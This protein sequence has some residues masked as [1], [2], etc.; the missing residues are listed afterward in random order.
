MKEFIFLLSL[1]IIT[2]SL[3]KEVSNVIRHQLWKKDVGYKSFPITLKHN[4]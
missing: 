3:I 1:S 4:Y 2:S